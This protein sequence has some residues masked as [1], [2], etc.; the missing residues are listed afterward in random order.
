[1]YMVLAL[2]ITLSAPALAS[3]NLDSNKP[4]RLSPHKYY[5]PYYRNYPR[6]YNRYYRPYYRSFYYDPFIYYPEGPYGDQYDRDLN[7]QKEYD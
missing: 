7:E 1:M 5:T 3:Y 4:Y 2:L 6:H